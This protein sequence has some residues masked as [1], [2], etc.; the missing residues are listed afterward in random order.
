MN[1]RTPTRSASGENFWTIS[2]LYYRSAQYGKA[3]WAANKNVVPDFD[4]LAVGDKIIIPPV[5]KLD[6]E[7][8]EEAPAPAQPA[9]ETVPADKPATLPA[10][11][12]APPPAGAPGPFGQQ[13]TQDTAVKAT[14]GIDPPV[15][16]P[17]PATLPA[18]L[19]APPPEGAPGP[20]GQQETQDTA[21]KATDGT[22]PPAASPKP[23]T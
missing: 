19:P 10:P 23:A 15:A 2:L 7:L 3:L 18:P 12:P 6:P 9:P 16:W 5:D 13:G 14:G 20:F 11:L 1:S 4:R 21:V 8:I 22:N 17:K